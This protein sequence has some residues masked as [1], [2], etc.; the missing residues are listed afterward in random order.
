MRVLF[1]SG[2]T[3]LFPAGGI[4]TYLEYAA[5]ALQSEGH[6]VFLFTWV[7]EGKN[8]APVSYGSFKPEN[9]HIQKISHRVVH[10]H[11]PSGSHFLSVSFWLSDKIASCA[12]AWNIDVVEATDYQAPCMAY[13][14]QHQTRAN[15]ACRVLSTFHHG[16]SEVIFEADQIGYPNWARANNVTER[17][18]M[19]ISD[20]VISPSKSICARLR[21][22]DIQSDIKI[23]REPY[24]FKKSLKP[25]DELS[26]V[27][28]YMGRLSIQKGVDKLIYLTNIMH[29]V[30]PL[31]KV[32]LIGRVG[33]TPFRQSDIIKYI[34][35]R[36]RP[37]LKESFLYASFRSREAALNLLEPKTISPHLGTDETFSYACIEAIDA[38]QLPIVR[39]G[40]AMAEFFPMDMQKYVLDGRMRSVRDTQT[41]LSEIVKNAPQIA[42]RVQEYC[43]ETLAPAR[44]ANELS[45]AYACALDRK[46]GWRAYP[47]A[48][49]PAG[50]N[51]ITVLIPAYKPNHEFMETIDSLA[52]QTA[53][54][55]RVLICNDGTPKGHEGWFDYAL[56]RLPDCNIITQPN[57]G[58]LAAR[59][60]LIENCQTD[61]SIFIDADDLFGHDLLEN[62]LVAWNESPKRPDAIIPQRAN[63]GESREVVLRHLLD[64]HIHILENDYR[65]TAL[66]RTKVLREIGFDSTRRNGEGEDWIFWLDFTG[67]SYCGLLL[68]TPGFFYRFRLGS[69]SWP[70][71]EGQNVGTQTML[72]EVLQEVAGRRPEKAAALAR[73]LFAEKVSK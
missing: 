32:E 39:D 27:V 70:W 31:R 65:M 46:K 58:L 26:N 62:M 64:D 19:R 29:S 52:N 18:Q 4:A 57:S 67:R 1:V 2:E 72:R 23:I 24:V 66:I 73:A 71:S 53:G 17:Q 10:E 43:R 9:V 51:D 16:L 25:M 45:T 33:F 50:L 42:T 7:E 44:Y 69:M 37:E 11:F 59:N 5:S 15:A 63:F 38:G 47:S 28:Q 30:F 54:V 8:A 21:S 48:R 34:E 35:T 49:L 13:F 36:L 20:L 3:P 41:I 40:T 56:A 68:P 60:T 22:L 14:Q 61:L 12:D 55:P 6:E